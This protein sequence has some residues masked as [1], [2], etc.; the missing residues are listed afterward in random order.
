MAQID[1]FITGA[2]GYIG[3]T[4]L[5]LLLDHKDTDHFNITA[6][7]RSAENAEKLKNATGIEV[8]VGSHSDLDVV[9]TLASKASVIFSMADC[10]DLELAK[11]KLRG[12]KKRYEA[13]GTPTEFIHISGTGC[14]VDESFGMYGPKEIID[15]I[16]SERIAALPI[17]QPHRHV[18]LELVEADLQGYVRT[19]IVVPGAVYGIATGKVANSGAQNTRNKL[20]GLFCH[21][22]F[23]RK[24]AFM[25]GEGKNE[26]PHIEI[27]EVSSLI[28][29]LYDSIMSSTTTTAHGKDG[30]YFAENGGYFLFE[31]SE[32]LQ[33]VLVEAGLP[34]VGP[35]PFSPEEG[36]KMG[37]VFLRMIGGNARC[38]SSRSRSLGWSPVRTDFLVSYREDLRIVASSMP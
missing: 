7:M 1:I 20:F 12:A 4:V 10:D 31:F 5:S 11:A 14:L 35:T 28:A 15:D 27:G 2:T 37:P 25:I 13:T 36:I 32:V 34:N 19:Y 21:M 38:K 22:S 33:E 23:A 30:Y 8:V 26:W 9:E 18:D 29:L 6:L 24:A 16:D 17:T 3:G